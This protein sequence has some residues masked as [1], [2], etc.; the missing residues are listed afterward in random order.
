MVSI[1]YGIKDV[2]R[3]MCLGY[4]YDLE[5]DPESLGTYLYEIKEDGTLGQ[6]FSVD[7]VKES[8]KK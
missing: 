8:V 6:T 5:D 4:D 1:V 2:E 7:C 3:K